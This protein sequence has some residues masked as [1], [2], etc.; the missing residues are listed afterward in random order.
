MKIYEFGTAPR[1]KKEGYVLVRTV[2][3]TEQDLHLRHAA[4]DLIFVFGP[5]VHG[6]PGVFEFARFERR[7]EI[8]TLIE[9]EISFAY[10]SSPAAT[11]F[12][13]GEQGC[14]T[15]KVGKDEKAL[16][17]LSLALKHA[18]SLGSRPSRWSIDHP[19]NA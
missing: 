3:S 6:R 8:P 17:S 19:L 5:S 10:P 7:E 16:T 2:H 18:E 11:R 13:F 9:H 15:I 1:A 4:E 12:G 14:Y